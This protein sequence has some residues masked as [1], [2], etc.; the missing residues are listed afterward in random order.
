[1]ASL[2]AHGVY[3][4]SYA[5]ASTR[6]PFV[7][8]PCVGSGCRLNVTVTS[9]MARQSNARICNDPSISFPARLPDRIARGTVCTSVPRGE[10]GAFE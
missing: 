4:M 9:V 10:Q 3:T 5:G 1:M 7:G 6:T 2:F 8:R